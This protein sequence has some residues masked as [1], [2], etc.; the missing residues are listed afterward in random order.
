MIC[1]DFCLCEFGDG[2]EPVAAGDELITDDAG[3][4]CAGERDDGGDA[5][6]A[7]EDGA[8][9][10]AVGAGGTAAVEGA[11]FDGVAVVGLEN[12]EG[13]VA[14]AGGVEVIEDRADEGIH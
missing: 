9:V 8:F 6:A 1:G 5:E 7:F 4:D 3:G 14:L 10:A 13:V 11:F 2:G 12:D